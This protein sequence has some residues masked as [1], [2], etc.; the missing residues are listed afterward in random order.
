MSEEKK[1]EVTED[2]LVDYALQFMYANLSKNELHLEKDVFASMNL[3]LN[4]EIV[5]HI[6]ELIMNT[7][8][9]NASI[10]FG[11]NG[12]MYLNTSGISV[13]KQ[14]KS[15]E[16][17]LQAQQVGGGI[18]PQMIEHKPAKKSNK[19]DGNK[20]TEDNSDFMRTVNEDD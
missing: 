9:V 11:K 8:L 14:Y 12:Y 15:Y 6:R 16:K 19:K 1:I 2:Q 7:N 20:S 3:K 17:Y 5:E 13:M 10:G 18:M 4:T